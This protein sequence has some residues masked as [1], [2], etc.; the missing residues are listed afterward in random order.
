MK[1][2]LQLIA[3][4]FFM[5]QTALAQR[6]FPVNGVKDEKHLQYA[7]THA[8]LQV[9]SKTVLDDATL[10]INDGLIEDAGKNIAIPE[11]TITYDLKGKYIYPS[12]ID[13]FSDYGLPEV[14]K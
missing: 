9:D 11:G 13:L 12:F 1:R 8:H 5:C 7:F 10:L 2:C 14:K 3:A 6:T 4:A